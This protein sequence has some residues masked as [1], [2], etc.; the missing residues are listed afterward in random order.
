MSHR[1]VE[2]GALSGGGGLGIVE[3]KVGTWERCLRLAE[4][5][6]IYFSKVMTF[7]INE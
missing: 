1:L 2:N 5:I 6:I 3:K 7:V 4:I